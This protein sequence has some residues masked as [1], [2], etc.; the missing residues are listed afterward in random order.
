MEERGWDLTISW[1]DVN[2]L[3]DQPKSNMFG[4]Q[5]GLCTVHSTFCQVHGL[6]QTIERMVHNRCN[7]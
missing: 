4:E 6:R 2:Y 7:G 3:A 5:M 1:G